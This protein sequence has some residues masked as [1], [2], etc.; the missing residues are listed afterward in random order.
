MPRTPSIRYFDSRKAYDTQY[1]GRQWLLAAGP[2]DEP[3]GPT[4]RKAVEQLA[5]GGAWK[6]QRGGFSMTIPR[7]L[8]DEGIGWE[9][10]CKEKLVCRRDSHS[11]PLPCPTSTGRGRQMAG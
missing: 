10:G 9:S 1:Q 5:N 3:D 4:Y 11:G 2:K 6:S 7:W 8:T